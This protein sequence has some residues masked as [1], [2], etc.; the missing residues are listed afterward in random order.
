M[1]SCPTV[2]LF[3][4]PGSIIPAAEAI[5]VD[6]R[7]TAAGELSLAYCLDG[8]LDQLRIPE[9]QLP[10]PADG[11]WEHT[12]FEAFIA[13][14]NSLAYREFNLSPSGQ[15]AAYAF[16]GYRERDEGV[17]LAPAPRVSVRRS[18]RRLELEAILPPGLLPPAAPG[19]GYQVGLS[20]VIEAAD[21]GKAYW[22]LAHPGPRPDF[23]LRTAFAL[24]LAA[25][26]KNT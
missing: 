12:C 16:S 5:E 24:P 15:W 3:S 23:H 14:G 1:P 13:A 9:P 26:N 7:F 25:P 19:A 20:A 6:V 17:T 21:G 2:A 18:A 22:A 11:L 8:S 4:F 10:G